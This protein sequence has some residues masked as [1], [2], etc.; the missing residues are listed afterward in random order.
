MQTFSFFYLFPLPESKIIH[1]SYT[2]F[3]P[4]FA[5]LVPFLPFRYLKFGALKFLHYLCIKFD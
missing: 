4:K 3:T 5:P 2:H 1:P